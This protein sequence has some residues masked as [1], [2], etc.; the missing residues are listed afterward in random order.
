MGKRAVIYARVSTDEQ[1]DNYSIPSQIKECLKYIEEKGYTLVGDQFVDPSGKDAEAGAGMIAAYVDDYTSMELDR[2]Q[3]TRALAFL[4]EYGYDILVV[5]ALD[6]LA[7]DPYIRQTLELQFKAYDENFRV[8]YALGRYEET[9]QGEV[10]KDM[11]ATFAKWEQATRVERSNRGKREKAAKGKF[12]GG[13]A[14]YGYQIN[15]NAKG[16]LEVIHEQAEIVKKIYDAFTGRGLSL[17]GIVRELNQEGARPQRGEKWGRSSVHRI[18]TNPVYAGYC[19]Y[20]KSKRK[21]MTRFVARDREEWI[22]FETTPILSQ[23]LYDRAR[24]TLEY[25]AEHVRKHPARFYLLSGHIFC[26]DCGKALLTQTAVAGGARRKNDAPVYRHRLSQGHC[27]NQTISARI[28][29]PKVTGKIVEML[30]DTE[31][32]EQAFIKANDDHLTVRGEKESELADLNGRLK[33]ATLKRENLLAAYTDPEIQLTKTLYLQQRDKVEAEINAYAG[34]IERLKRQI[35]NVLIDDLESIFTVFKY[36]KLK[37]REWVSA[38]MPDFIKRFRIRVLVDQDGGFEIH[39]L[40]TP[41][42]VIALGNVRDEEE[43]MEMAS[44][45]WDE[46]AGDLLSTAYSCSDQQISRLNKEFEIL[47]RG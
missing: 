6:R 32:L 8:E 39:G 19:F 27:R 4:K 47:I 20:N 10:M 9:P 5:H 22:K 18:L 24:S 7:R 37:N 14:P 34:K 44:A 38:N 3:L 15:K 42:D 23:A 11:T 26:R 41:K 2:P 35:D 31:K 30:R 36:I 33:K 12:V 40:V 28:L 21:G 29:E 46:P 16:G 17:H 45:A 43:L 13:R 1:R 25:N